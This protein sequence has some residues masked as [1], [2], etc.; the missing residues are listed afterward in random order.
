MKTSVLLVAICTCFFTY[1][2]V[3]AQSFEG[4]ITYHFTY[5]DKTGK[6]FSSQK[7]VRNLLGNRQV[8]YY[9]HGKYRSRLN[10]KWEKSSFYLGDDKVY[11]TKKYI[12]AVMWLPAAKTPSEVISYKI[13]R[14][15]K[16]IKGW[17]C[18]LLEVKME[19]GTILC[20]YHPR[21]G[22]EPDSYTSHNYRLWSYCISKTGALPLKF[23]YES[24]KEYLELTVDE[25]NE[26]MLEDELFELPADVSVIIDSDWKL[27]N[28]E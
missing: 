13:T 24:N 16:R 2:T 27:I 25:V 1:N 14:D 9:K 3:Q 18:D 15:A 19:E 26:K 6:L 8:Y 20:Y 23:I 12:R 11:S 21:I 5:K 28:K 17:R 4:K 7:D 22:A 10:G